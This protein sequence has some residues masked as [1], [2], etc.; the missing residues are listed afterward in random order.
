MLKIDRS[1]YKLGKKAPKVDTRTLKLIDYLVPILP[2]VPPSINWAPTVSWPMLMNDT[3][4]NCI[5]ASKLHAIQVW[6]QNHPAYNPTDATALKYY[7]LWDGYISGDPSTDNGGVIID[8]LNDWR[9][10]KMD[11]HVLGA[12]VAPSVG[13]QLHIQ[14]SIAFFGG[15]DLGI[16][17]PVSALSQTE[18]TVVNPDGGIA[19]GHD[20]YIF[21][22]NSIGPVCATWNETIQMTWQFFNTYVDEAYTLLGNAFQTPIDLINWKLLGQDLASV[23]N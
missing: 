19:G 15:V 5:I 10:Q 7:E 12:Y 3:L 4:G 6:V 13:N 17:L 1:N 9:S 16:Q 14:Q 21:A 8:V 18:W 2:N 11:G 22:Y 23:T 20:V